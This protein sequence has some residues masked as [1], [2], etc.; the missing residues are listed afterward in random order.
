LN[1]RKE[2]QKAM[3]EKTA[4]DRHTELRRASLAAGMRFSAVSDK[5]SQA[6]KAA[7]QLSTEKL[8]AEAELH[9]ANAELSAFVASQKAGKAQ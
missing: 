7:G 1:D 6:V 9:N 5:H 2:L 8:T 4:N 3:S